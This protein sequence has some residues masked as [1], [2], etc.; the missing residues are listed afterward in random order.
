MI[1]TF[2]NCLFVHIP[3]TAG[4]SVESVFLARAG[5]TWEQ[6]E[7]FLLMKNSNPQKGPPRLAHLTALEYLELGYISSKKFEQFFKFAVVRNPWDR[8]VSEY[9]YQQYPYSFKDFI[10]KHFPVLDQD[11]YVKHHGHYRHVMPQW[12]FVCDKDGQLIVDAIIK[13]ESLQHDFNKV[14]LAITQQEI[15]LPHRNK[16]VANT[17]LTKIKLNAKKL[18]SSTSTDNLHYSDYY[19]AESIKWVVENYAKDISMFDYSFEDK[20]N[21]QMT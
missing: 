16:T 5:L 10:F 3:K 21:G 4:Q 8:L 1:S 7:E 6:R 20:F 11:D 15:L 17:L 9:C 13:F 19:D 14:S 12:Q 2:D 18:L